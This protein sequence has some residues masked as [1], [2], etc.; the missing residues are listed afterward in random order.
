[1]HGAQ[2]GKQSI[3]LAKSCRYLVC[4]RRSDGVRDRPRT[5]SPVANHR[6]LISWATRRATAPRTGADPR[7]VGHRASVLRLWLVRDRSAEVSKNDR[8]GLR[9]RDVRLAVVV[10]VAVRLGIGVRGRR[11]DPAIR[12]RFP[13]GELAL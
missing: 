6:S 2:S 1:M 11:V 12:N 8:D 10:L 4:L 9:E 13:F 5:S 3:G 7:R